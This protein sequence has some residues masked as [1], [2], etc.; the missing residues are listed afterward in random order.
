MQRARNYNEKADI[1]SLGI[2]C[3]E[4]AEGEPPYMRDQNV[5]I[6]RKT[7]LQSMPRINTQKWSAEFQD[8]IDRCLVKDPEQRW[9]AEMLLHH[10][11][12]DG[13]ESAQEA[14]CRDYISWESSKQQ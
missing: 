5:M 3:M 1:W 14:W 8:F 12:M 2:F 9:S 4:L 7:L 10:P 11:F 13:A 6:V